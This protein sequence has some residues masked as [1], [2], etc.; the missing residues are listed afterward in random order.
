ME[1][2]WSRLNEIDKN[3]W[4]I[5]PLQPKPHHLHRRIYLTQSLSVLINIDPLNPADLP[6][7][8]LLGSDTEV[9]KY[10]NIMSENLQKWDSE[11]NLLDN[12]MTLLNVHEFPQAS[13][14]QSS[15]ENDG[16]VAEEECCICFSLELDTGQFPE[17][18][19]NN[20]KCKRQFHT[21]CLLQWLQAIA[22][23][24]IVFGHIHGT[25]PHCGESMSCPVAS[26]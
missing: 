15:T 21:I 16:I 13:T 8:K 2:A 22:G 19:C 14:I 6:D 26:H 5:D 18:T 20:P 12:L 7:I 10:R 4:I 3:C 25:C 24:Q 23:N 1:S 11:C 9:A 17:K